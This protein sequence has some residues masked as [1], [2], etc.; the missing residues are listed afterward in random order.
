MTVK[1]PYKSDSAAKLPAILKGKPNGQIPAEFLVPCGL[2]KFLMVEPAAGAMRA[3][4]A[5]AAGDGVTLSATGTWRSYDQ[6][7]AMFLDRYTTTNN[8]GKTKTWEGKTYW[9]KPKVAMA[10]APGTSNHGLGLAVDLSDSPSIPI[11][12]ASLAWLANHG[13]SF[14]YWN[15]VQS[16]NWHWTYCLGDD[17]PAGVTITVAASVSSA[18][19]AGR[20][21]NEE[22]A[23]AAVAAVATPAA[24]DWQAIA[25]TDAKM[26]AVVFPGELIQ[27]AQGEAVSAVQ[28]KLVAAGQD[29]KVDGDFGKKTAAAV[30]GFQTVNSLTPDGRVGPMTWN[31]LGLHPA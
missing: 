29:V 23:A 22:A 30:T 31:A 10:A 8:G 15:T 27:G 12:A 1:L 6:Q 18:A 17:A 19:H 4:V 26:M 11:G 16:E 14:G 13:P 2:R 3:M 24:V 7:K 21:A 25:A 20:V 5:A 28:W 9:Q